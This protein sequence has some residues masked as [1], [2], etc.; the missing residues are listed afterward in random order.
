METEKNV[1]EGRI[2]PVLIGVLGVAWFTSMILF[3]FFVPI[4]PMTL[5]PVFLF[6]AFSLVVLARPFPGYKRW[7]ILRLFDFAILPVCGWLAWLFYA[8]QERIITRIPYIS[9]VMPVDVAACIIMMLLLM[10]TMRRTIGWNLLV[11]VLLFILYGVFGPH[12]PSV[13][14]FDGF[15]MEQFTE[16]MSLT[17]NGVYGTALSTTAS[18]IFFFI[19]FGSI[20]AACGGGQVLIDIGM[21]FSDPSSGG[22][23]KAAVMSSALM[24]MISGSAVANVSTT[25]VMTIPMMKKAGYKPEQ[26]AAIEAVASTGGQIMPPIMGVGAFIMAELLGMNYGQIALCA[27]IPAVAYFGSVF[28]LVGLVA[29]KNTYING[30]N[31]AAE[32]LTFNVAP[33]VPRLF[34]LIPGVILVTMVLTGSSLRISAVY[35]TLAILA[36]NLINP[37]RIGLRELYTAFM[38][39]IRQSANITIPVAACGVIIGVVVQSGLANKFTALLAVLGGTSLLLAL[40]I[41][42]LCCMVLG[43]AMPTVAAYL[44][45][46]TLF[47]SALVKL[48]LPIL[49]VH[50]FCFYFGVISQITPPVCLASFTAAG[51]ADADSWKT[52]W[53][54]FIYA[55]VAFLVPFA[56]AYEPALLL[57][58]PIMNTILSS[59]TLYIGCYALAIAI[60]GFYTKPLGRPLRAVFLIASF[61]CVVPGLITDCIGIALLILAMYLSRRAEPAI[62]VAN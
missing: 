27:T 6:F 61:L 37:R 24:G 10:E 25:G 1:L 16:I 54:G 44:I 53:T 52:G 33:I 9:D 23:A 22:P 14:S 58:G 28:M 46:V 4:N 40:I 12:M 2:V 56:F 26:A 35:A 34:L 48:D 51:I 55:S 39:G 45:S 30:A 32:E 50:M 18:Y 57:Q 3:S 29:K 7:P 42:M 41:A 20:F 47:A 5:A 13:F 8:D 21:K 38:D 62:V 11:F 36:L 15:N 59:A 31:V 43:M 17:S 49:V 19:I 60:S